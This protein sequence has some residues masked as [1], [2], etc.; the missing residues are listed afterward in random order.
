M[1]S[2]QYLK[3]LK[4][5]LYNIHRRCLIEN[6]K[7]NCVVKYLQNLINTFKQSTKKC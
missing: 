2:F 1:I 4:K 6:K 5:G 7:K 3:Q